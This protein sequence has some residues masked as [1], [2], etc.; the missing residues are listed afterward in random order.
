MPQGIIFVDTTTGDLKYQ[1]V[2]GTPAILAEANGSVHLIPYVATY[3]G[4]TGIHTN[5]TTTFSGIGAIIFNPAS[6]FAGNTKITRTLKF[7]TIIEATTGVTTEIRLYNISTGAAVTGTTLTTTAVIPTLVESTLTIGASPNLPN[8]QQIYEIQLRIS[9]P[10][11]PGVT[12]LAIC[13]LAQILV[14]WS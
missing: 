2:T 11:S 7:Q 13:K 5:D 12:D 3:A 10:A 9:L 1:G 14:T 6:I 4:T 8:S